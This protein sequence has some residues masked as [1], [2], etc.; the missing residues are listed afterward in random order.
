VASAGNSG[1]SP[2]RIDGGHS[3][4]THIMGTVASGEELEHQLEVWNASYI[5]VDLWYNGSDTLTFTLE[6]PSDTVSATTGDGTV[7][8]PSGRAQISAPGE[9]DAVNGDREAFVEILDSDVATYRLRVRGVNSAGVEPYHGWLVDGIA[10]FRTHFSNSHLVLTPGTATRAIE[11]AA[12]T[13]RESWVSID[14]N[15]YS[16]GGSRSELGQITAWS[17]VGPRRD[18]VLKPEIAAPGSA[19][20]SSASAEVDE[21]FIALTLPDGVHSIKQGTSMSSPHAAG[22]VALFLQAN[23][24]LTPEDIVAVLQAT[25][26]EDYFSRESYADDAGTVG[27]P[28][29]TW[30]HGKLD[31]L[32]GLQQIVGTAAAL[33]VAATADEPPLERIP[34]QAQS[35]ELLR[36]D[37]T[38]GPEFVQVTDLRLTPEGS[39]DFAGLAVHLYVEPFHVRLL[40]DGA[41]GFELEESFILDLQSTSE[42]WVVA[43]FVHGG[44]FGDE[45][46]LNLTALEAE[47]GLS[48]TPISPTGLPVAGW[49]RRLARGA[50]ALQLAPSG[51]PQPAPG[52][53][54]PGMAVPLIQLYGTTDSVEPLRMDDI[55]LRSSIAD[56]E[57]RLYVVQYEP[58]EP[59]VFPGV[60][61][62]TIYRSEPFVSEWTGSVFTDTALALSLPVG[63]WSYEIGALLSPAAGHG[64]QV[65][66]KL[67]PDS[68][69]ILGVISGD[70]AQQLTSPDSLLAGRGGI[71]LLESDEA[72][73]LSANPVRGQRVVFTFGTRPRAVSVFNFAGERVRLF[74]DADIEGL[75]GGPARIVWEPIENDR[76]S[77]L[78]NGVYL[79]V[80]EHADGRVE[81]QRLMILRGRR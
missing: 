49:L 79:L 3:D 69:C 18:G 4:R 1:S 68:V 9:R 30:G 74:R 21:A 58:G 28:N 50:V 24:D 22:A 25:G 6:G 41:G 56:P 57:L 27:L 42:A 52:T 54:L 71:N 11:V 47:G 73:G 39:L 34:R 33:A 78:A 80:I 5:F 38:T 7:V 65:Q 17:S 72:F 31:V 59:P 36:F 44:D 23:P 32:A 37:L 35:V 61:G 64:S 19:I 62:D 20:A 26:R 12:Y 76:G 70:S 40:P 81:R 10:E 13:T 77:E 48:G 51:S 43:D 55:A 16:F 8:S 53:V 60:A 75:E 2:V 29:H 15:T 67:D 66:L 14:G 63:A 46:R 45:G